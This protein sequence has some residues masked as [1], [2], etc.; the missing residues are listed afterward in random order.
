V[1]DGDPILVSYDLAIDALF[2]NWVVKNKHKLQRVRVCMRATESVA[3]CD[4]SQ[5]NR[6]RANNNA[7]RCNATSTWHRHA[8][9]DTWHA[10][11]P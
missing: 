6:A 11:A 5:L 1:I 4:P 10:A 8:T 3:L 7:S 9:C 2:F